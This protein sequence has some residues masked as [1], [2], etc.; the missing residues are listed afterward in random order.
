MSS[1]ALGYVKFK[2][3][4]AD[5]ESF[6]TDAVNNGIKIFDVE[7]VKGIYYAKTLPKDYIRLTKLKRRYQIQIRITERHGIAFKL[8][9]YKYR[10]GILFGAAAFCAIL[11]FC[12]SLVRDISV[13]GNER[14]PEDAILDFL[15][16]NGMYPRVP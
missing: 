1:K 14:I 7:N 12:S 16:E 13:T 6:F 5:C 9:K 11:Y 15:S 2:L 4:G 3:L 8:Y 10:Y